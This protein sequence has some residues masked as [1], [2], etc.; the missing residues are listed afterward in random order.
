VFQFNRHILADVM[1]ICIWR[2]KTTVSHELEQ[3]VD[4]YLPFV[5]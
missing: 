5:V 1:Y 3:D 4:L 2:M